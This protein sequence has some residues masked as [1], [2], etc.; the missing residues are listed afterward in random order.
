MDN[1]LISNVL[2]SLL[3]SSIFLFSL[4]ENT[5]ERIVVAVSVLT[6]WAFEIHR[7]VELICPWDIG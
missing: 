4:E 3:I 6:I 2:I 5:A 7:L 1:Y